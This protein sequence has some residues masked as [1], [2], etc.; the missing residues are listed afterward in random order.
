MEFSP[1]CSGKSA[2]SSEI[3]AFFETTIYFSSAYNVSVHALAATS[4]EIWTRQR[5]RNIMVSAI[6]GWWEDTPSW[7]KCH[8]KNYSDMQ[9][10]RFTAGYT[11]WDHIRN[12]VI[13]KELQVQ[14]VLDF[15]QKIRKMEWPHDPYAQK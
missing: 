1:L 12:D 6:L 8:E 7:I 13:M 5:C 15:I 14:P 11:K 4:S 9:F 2:L 10:M 3:F